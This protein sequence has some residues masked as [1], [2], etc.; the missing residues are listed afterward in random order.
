[1]R[2]RLLQATVDCLIESGYVNTTTTAVVARA[3]VSRGAILHHFP[4]KA[5]LVATAVEYV[6]EQRNAQ[7][8]DRFSKLPRDETLVDAVIASLWE[9]VNGTMFH[10]WIE[11]VV[12]SRTDKELHKK[13]KPLAARWM[14]M[15]DATFRLV[16][17]VE[18]IP[19][20]HPLALAPIVTM[21][22]LYGLAFEKIARPDDPSLEKRVLRALKT[23]APLATL[24]Y[25][26]A[27]LSNE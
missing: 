23:I 7:F 22:V 8:R 15:I 5:D 24:P 27:K 4:T 6:L 17:G 21:T 14:E 3:G 2:A 19:E 1:M 25:L 16:F 26:P 18:R 9:E 20:K 10:A 11:L 12:A 13:V